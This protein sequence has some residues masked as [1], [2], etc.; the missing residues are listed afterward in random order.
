MGWGLQLQDREE[1]REAELLGSEEPDTPLPLTVTSRVTASPSPTLH[2]SAVLAFSSFA[3]TTK[4]FHLSFS[5]YFV[6]H[7]LICPV[8][9]IVNAI[10][11]ALH[12]GGYN[13]GASL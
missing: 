13:G 3:I 1:D 4:H 10:T 6:G 9:F 8:W 12:V 7:K 11:V 2:L 5:I